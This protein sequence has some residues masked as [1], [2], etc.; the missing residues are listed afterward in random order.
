MQLPISKTITLFP[1]G[2]KLFH[3]C[4]FYF[5]EMVSMLLFSPQSLQNQYTQTHLNK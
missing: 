5:N 1:R 4:D 3:I 2:H